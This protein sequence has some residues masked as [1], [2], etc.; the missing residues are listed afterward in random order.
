[1]QFAEDYQADFLTQ[2][3][4]MFDQMRAAGYLQGEMIWNFA[5]FATGQSIYRIGGQ[6]RCVCGHSARGNDALTC[7]FDA[8]RACSRGSDSQRWRRMCCAITTAPSPTRQ[9][10]TMFFS[11]NDDQPLS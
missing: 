1:V 7:S 5:D 2:Y 6:N 8:G 3:H 4:A 10:A 11:P 9:A